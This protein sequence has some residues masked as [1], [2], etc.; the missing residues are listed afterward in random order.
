MDTCGFGTR[1][2]FDLAVTRRAVSVLSP[3]DFFFFFCFFAF[4]RSSV[5]VA[6]F[7]EEHSQWVFFFG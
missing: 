3:F 2:W 5:E 4:L 7:Y 6:L 1:V